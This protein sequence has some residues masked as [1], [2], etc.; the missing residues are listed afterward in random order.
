MLQNI[1]KLLSYLAITALP[2]LY[3]HNAF[4]WLKI[5]SSRQLVARL[6]QLGSLLRFWFGL[7]STM[8]GFIVLPFSRLNSLWTFFFLNSPLTYHHYRPHEQLHRRVPMGIP[9]NR[10]NSEGTLNVPKG[11]RFLRARIAKRER[12]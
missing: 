6:L 12:G 3:L 9:Q 2:A 7:P 1:Y 11:S 4:L 10:N 5:C 8:N